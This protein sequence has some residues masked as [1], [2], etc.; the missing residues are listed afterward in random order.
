MRDF[1]GVA[2]FAIRNRLKFHVGIILFSLIMVPGLQQTLT[3]I[4]V[5]SYDMDS[6]EMDAE[7]VIDE[8]FSSK[9][10]TLGFVISIRDPS[11]VEN[12]NQ[13]PHT[14][15]DGLP[16]R[17]ALPT[18][19]EITPFQG[20]GEGLSGEGI[21][22]GGVFNLTFLQE[23][24]QKIMIVRNDPLSAYYRPI[25]SEVTGESSNGTLSLYE[26]F[27][28]F[29][30]N[31]SLLTRAGFDPFG[32]VIPPLTN[33]SDCGVLECLRF[34]DE[35]VTQAHVDLAANRMILAK[36]SLF[37]RWTTTDR[38][39]LPDSDS[40]VIGPVGGQVG[41]DGTFQNAVWMPGRWSASAT[42]ILIQL[43]KVDMTNTGYTFV[44]NDAR[45][46]P[47][48]MTWHG[49]KLYTTP[50]N[51]TQEECLQSQESGD[52]PCSA[53]WALLSLEQNIR[54]NDQISVTMLAPPH[55][56]NVE[57]NRE[58]QQSV[59]LLATMFACIMILLWVSLR[60]VSDVAIV[61]TTLGFSLLWMQGLI[62]WGMIAGSTFDIKIISRSQFSNL[63]P[64]LILALGI[65]DSLHALH[66]YKE[67]R[68]KGKTTDEAVHTSLSRVGRAIML[69]SLT[70]IA[71]FSANLTSSIPALRSFGLEAA[72]G[73]AS[74]FVLTGLWAPLIRY[75]IDQWMQG[76]GRLEEDTGNRLYMV[77]KHWLSRISGGSAWAA[78]GVIII[79]LILT[80][81][82][83]PMMLSLEGDFNI[84]DFLD[85]E[86]DIAQSVL[87]INERFSSEGEPGVILIEGDILDPKVFDAI[88]ELRYNMNTAGPED[89]RRFTTLPTGEIEMHAIDELVNW[90]KVS[91]AVNPEPFVKAGWNE[92]LPGNGVDCGT[93]NGVPDTQSRGCLQFLYGYLTTYGIPAAGI[94]PQIP[95]SIP[96]LYV[97]P[98][99]ELNPNATHLCTDGSNP[100]YVRMTMRWGLIR[101]EQFTITALA[102]DELERDMAPFANLSA[103]TMDTRSSLTSSSEEYPVT[104]AIPTGSPVTRYVAA[105]SMQNE[106]QG[107][108]IL[109][110]YLCLITLWW[111]FRP[112]VNQSTAALRRGKEEVALLASWGLLAGFA[113][114][115]VMAQ[116]YGGTVGGMCGLAIF[117][118][119][120]F[121]GERALTFALITTFPILIVVV[122]LY[123]MIAAG[124]YGLNMVTVAIATMSLGVGID[125]V[126][127]VVERYREERDKGRSV[128]SSLVAMGGASGLALVGSAVSD[129]TGFAIISFSP[130]G[131][132]SLFGLFCALMIALSFIASM[133][134]ASS[135]LGMIAWGEIRRESKDAGGIRQLQIDAERRLGIRGGVA[136]D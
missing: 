127:H 12:G 37:M 9:E 75:D 23:L 33:W 107:S 26:Q 91:L 40:P 83:T 92:S 78:P 124:G 70:T 103:T 99:C 125:Y 4:D 60:R 116:F 108:L 76:R 71:A 112:G 117:I 90:T 38:A 42:W 65:D 128:H 17:L 80:A 22:E 100:Q 121:W 74:A 31:R 135:V 7:R 110:V 8:E 27:E 134:I 36:P 114:G 57:V 122:W 120:F 52:G 55:G 132:F 64:I 3:P 115:A 133:I 97:S 93:I 59:T 50:P 119:N 68:N 82:A 95:P 126:I 129:V 21:P 53:D 109:G 98:E 34:D 94:I 89:P 19:Q 47:D 41:E 106:L 113:I 56:I 48:S 73:V 54:V 24:E 20:D 118:L 13:A 10:I 46:E 84:D 16:D 6:P 5:D 85:E 58:L 67:E 18:P 77:P 96:L 51:L 32:N 49:L 72:L 105:S 88:S 43:D 79:T 136:D 86:S 45:S 14:G 28:S 35:N 101:P 44:W 62:G 131:F 2:S 1:S 15:A 29:M 111:G 25:V 123:G 39:F 130:M 61:V 81:I 104:W 63:L 87:L 69:T 102:L 11:F 30:A 66:R